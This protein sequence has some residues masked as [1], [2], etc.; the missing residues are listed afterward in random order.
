MPQP[1]VNCLWILFDAIS[2][3]MVDVRR[4]IPEY[5]QLSYNA[6]TIGHVFYPNPILTLFV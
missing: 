2:V 5:D 4:R 6:K 1:Q 3:A